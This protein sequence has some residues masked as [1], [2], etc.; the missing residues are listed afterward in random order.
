M[1]RFLCAV[2][3]ACLATCLAAC[4]PGPGPE[5]TS[6]PT[7]APPFDM[8]YFSEELAKAA[9][10]WMVDAFMERQKPY[11]WNE[12]ARDAIL[13]A[14]LAHTST[15]FEVGGG[16]APAPKLYRI[17]TFGGVR[18]YTLDNAALARALQGKLTPA[19]ERYLELMALERMAVDGALAVPYDTLARRILLWEAFERDHAAFD[20][21]RRKTENLS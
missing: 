8:D 12:E 10:P 13:L 6:E 3:A 16:E 21:L 9:T 1:K 2:L 19:G 11:L 4:G 20:Q 17:E 7:S 15:G 14:I 5:P 18:Y